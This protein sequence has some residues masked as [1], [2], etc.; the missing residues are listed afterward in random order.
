MRPEWPPSTRTRPV[1]VVGTRSRRFLSRRW[2]S[3]GPGGPSGAANPRQVRPESGEG[4]A[5]VCARLRM[6]G[7]DPEFLAGPGAPVELPQG[8]SE[9]RP[10]GPRPRFV[11]P[12]E[13]PH[14]RRPHACP[15]KS[16]GSALVRRT[17][18]SN[19]CRCRSRGASTRASMGLA[20]GS[21]QGR[22]FTPSFV[23]GFASGCFSRPRPGAP[24]CGC[25]PIRRMGLVQQWTRASPACG[26]RSESK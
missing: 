20:P 18:S 16:E 13:L 4:S 11:Y 9:H 12:A 21:E 24:R 19:H 5:T 25:R 8:R 17:V 26:E 14:L 7:T 23:R 15:E 6:R 3:L 22:R 10:G 1:D 2:E